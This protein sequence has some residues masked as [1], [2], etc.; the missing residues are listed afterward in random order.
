[1]D[2]P[3]KQPTTF[4]K[5]SIAKTQAR[6]RSSW[7]SSLKQEEY[8]RL[9]CR[10]SLRWDY[11]SD[12]GQFRGF[13]LRRGYLAWV[14]QSVAQNATPRLGEG[15]SKKVWASFCYSR[16]GETSSLGRKY[17]LSPLFTHTW[18]HTQPKYIVQTISMRTQ[19]AYKHILMKQKQTK[20]QST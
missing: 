11:D 12:F 9:S 10:L 1:M 18:Q 16:L 19:T 6:S 20:Q 13:S 5:R 14:R 3:I 4:M 2:Q 15:S 17:Q 7:E 8:S